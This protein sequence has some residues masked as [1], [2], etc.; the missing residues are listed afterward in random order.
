MLKGEAVRLWFKVSGDH[1]LVGYY[2]GRRMT[3]VSNKEKVWGEFPTPPTIDET[4]DFVTDRYDI[5]L[6]IGDLLVVNPR[7]SLVSDDT[8]GGVAG[9]ETIDGV[10]C[11]HLVWHH[12][13]VDWSVWIPVSGDPLPKKLRITY[14]ER[15]GQPTTTVMFRDWN[16]TPNLTDAVFVR[17]V[18]NDYEGIPVIQRAAAVLKDEKRKTEPPQK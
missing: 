6:P 4:V 18:P 7:E 9:R 1:D 15:R 16:L 10:L 5:P 11:E 14:K 13:K 17:S 12:P 2:E 3:L 8:T